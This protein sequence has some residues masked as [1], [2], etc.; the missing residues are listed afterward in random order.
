MTQMHTYGE[1]VQILDDELSALLDT[2]DRLTPAEWGVETRLNLGNRPGW[3]VLTTAVHIGIS[4][5]MLPE[6]VSE[7]AVGVTEPE[8]T[9]VTHFIFDVSKFAPIVDKLARDAAEG[10]TPQSAMEE[11]RR[12]VDVTVAAA[13]NNPPD[14]IGKAFFGTMRLDDVLPTR[15]LEAAVHGLD[16]S[17]ALGRDPYLTAGARDVTAHL[18]DELFEHLHGEARPAELADPVTFIET[19]MG[20]RNSDDPRFPLA[21]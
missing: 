9:R 20:R 17:D 14:F 7:P 8:I 12:A 16:I 15:V 10:A 21:Q 3:D 4:M 6:V 18:M 19:A 2:L 13:R 5:S 11:L 1:M